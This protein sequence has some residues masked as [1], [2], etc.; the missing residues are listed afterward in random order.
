[1]KVR[2]SK[3]LGAVALAAGS[4]GAMGVAQASPTATYVGQT[5]DGPVPLVFNAN[6]VFT[7]TSGNPSAGLG[8]ISGLTAND[9]IE[10]FSTPNPAVV[11]LSAGTSVGPSAFT[12]P[13][14]NPGFFIPANDFFLGLDV[15]SGSNNNF[16]FVE[17]DSAAHVVGYAFETTPNTAIVTA[18]IA[19]GVPEPASIALLAAGAAGI[20]GIRR[21]R[22]SRAAPR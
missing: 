6:T 14:Q 5:T 12:D 9:V 7:V 13:A 10:S 17:I 20:A 2:S 3:S 15:V 18:E 1:M 19:R 16:G 22:T 4:L 11:K 8:T 21:R